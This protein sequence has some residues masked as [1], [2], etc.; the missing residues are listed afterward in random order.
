M[1][2][3]QVTANVAAVTVGDRD[4]LTNFELNSRT[5]KQNSADYSYLGKKH[6]IAAAPTRKLKVIFNH[7]VLNDDD[8][9][10]FVTVDSYEKQ[11]YTSDIPMIR[12]CCCCI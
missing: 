7:Y 2:E 1:Q 11:R 8:P 3:S 5:K 10:D 9:G 4:I 6:L 12:R